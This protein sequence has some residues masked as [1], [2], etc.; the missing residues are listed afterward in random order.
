MGDAKRRGIWPGDILHDIRSGFLGTSLTPFESMGFKHY[1]ACTDVKKPPG[2]SPLQRKT[3]KALTSSQ[4]T[5]KAKSMGGR[6][7]K[8]SASTIRKAKKGIKVAA[9]QRPIKKK[10]AFARAWAASVRA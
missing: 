8:S 5:T 7:C 4:H 3:G 6:V 2:S 9:C 10:S 1:R